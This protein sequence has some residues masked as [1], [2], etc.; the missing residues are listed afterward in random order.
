MKKRDNSALT[1]SDSFKLPSQ[2]NGLP[3]L[4]K[5]RRFPD[6]CA[7]MSVWICDSTPGFTL[8]ERDDSEWGN[9]SCTAPPPSL[10]CCV[11]NGCTA[12][13][14]CPSVTSRHQRWAGGAPCSQKQTSQLN[15]CANSRKGVLQQQLFVLKREGSC[16]QLFGSQNSSHGQRRTK[17][18]IIKW[19]RSQT[20]ASAPSDARD[21]LADL[22]LRITTKDGEFFHLDAS[23]DMENSYTLQQ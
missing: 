7:Q 18:S 23:F 20:R 8:G 1:H 16:A 15:P 6:V 2:P 14:S 4:Q 12:C 19:N 10:F 21:G 13:L 22:S 5:C 9:T 11:D 3:V 17:E